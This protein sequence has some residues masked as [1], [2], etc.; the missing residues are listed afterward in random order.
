MLSFLL[1]KIELIGVAI[2]ALFGF[3]L[4]GKNSKLIR[5][6]RELMLNNSTQ[7]EIIKAQQEMLHAAKNTKP[8][9]IAGNIK[10]MRNK[11]L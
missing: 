3:I 9:D 7:D 11:K 10:R 2:I 6:N 8:T 5:E 1:S 4:Q